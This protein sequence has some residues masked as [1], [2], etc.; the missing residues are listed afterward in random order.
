MME[1]KDICDRMLADPAPPMTCA[2]DLL[3]F[4]RRSRARHRARLGAGFAAAATLAVAAAAPL[5]VGGAP[6]T[7][8][9]IGQAAPATSAVPAPVPMA[10][11]DLLPVGFDSSGTDD[12]RVIYMRIV[13]D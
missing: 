4:A 10:F 11:K 13:P 8:P 3:S 6:A 1:V 2:D 5:L 7:R 9:P 12:S